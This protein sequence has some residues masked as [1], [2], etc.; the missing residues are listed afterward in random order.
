M[1]PLPR[2]T[3]RRLAIGALLP[4]AG[5]GPLGAQDARTAADAAHDAQAARCGAPARR[6]LRQLPWPARRQP[7]R[8]AVDRRPAARASGRAPAHAARRCRRRDADAPARQ[9]LQRRRDRAAGG[10]LRAAAAWT[11]DRPM[12]VQ[13]RLTRRRLLRLRRRGRFARRH[14]RLQPR[15]A[16]DRPGARDRGRRRLRRRHRGALP[17][18]VVRRRDRRHAGRTEAHATSRARCPTSCSAAPRRWTR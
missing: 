3:M 9:G 14:G 8:H 5:A 2:L 11:E 15:R 4:L 7:G 18:A 12:T 17:A 6:H 16:P 10:A 13:L 1:T